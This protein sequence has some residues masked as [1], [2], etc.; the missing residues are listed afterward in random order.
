L[1]IA[2][3]PDRPP[4]FRIQVVDEQTGRG[5]PLVEL[6]T[7]N[8][9]RYVTDSNGVV[10]FDEPG[11]FDRKVFFSVSSHGYEAAKDG[12]GFPGQAIQIT[13]GGSARIS[14]RRRNIA[15]RLYRVTGA[16]I[17]RDSVLTGDRVS[18][19]EPLLNGRV[20]GQDSVVNA[21]YRGKV[22]WFWG[23]TNRPDYP[24]GN[25]HAPGATSALPGHGGLDPEAGVDLS[26]FLDNSGFARPTA[27]IPGDG[28]TW[29]SGLV[30]LRD[31]DGNE[32]MFANYAKI[33]KMLE[34]YQQGLAEF[35]PDSGRFEKVSQFPDLASHPVDFPTGHTFVHT[36]H[37]VNYVYY[38]NPY[39]LIRVP[40][41]PDQLGNPTAIEAYT[42]LKP[43][44]TRAQA[45]LDRGADGSLRYSWKKKTQVL[46]Q[47]TQNK[48]IASGRI[49]P[50]EALLNLRDVET[51]KTVLGHG[52][53]V[54]WNSFR[55]RW[56][57]IAVESFGGPSFLGEVW[58][59]EGDTPLGPWV[60]ARKV[61][62]HNKYSFYNPKQHPMFDKDGG[63]II[64]FEGTYTT[65]FSGNDHPTPRYDYN[66]VMYRLDLADRR[67]ALPVA[68]YELPAGDGS[69]RF[70][71][72][73]GLKESGEG[74]PRQVAF[75]AP[76]RPGIAGVPVYEE[77]DPNDGRLLRLG[78]GA[79]TPSDRSTA[80]VFY[81]LPDD[82]R[83][84][85]E[86]TVRLYEHQTQAGGRRS[87]SVDPSGRK[88]RAARPGR[89]LGRVW[90]NP[91]TA[92]R[93]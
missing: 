17:Y 53:S 78:T 69:V 81:V 31:R 65:T 28:P 76:D 19:R 24:L 45:Q 7:V 9:V 71:T 63:R 80:P 82:P 11:L 72:R 1:G 58:Y 15:E 16:G 46:P 91:A 67:L 23:D 51:G 56:V 88:V 8:Q 3:A 74:T 34:V 85:D 27:P 90:P 66:Q 13:D 70:T 48:Q 41:D 73:S 61:V 32:R 26:Y 35:R 64:F 5:V 83:G 29:L 49:K 50:R 42:C 57:M 52:G 55:G 62:T 54:Y 12:F 33:R 6:K 22:Y 59:A 68:V 60:Y 87:Y 20:F 43:G 25:F 75:F 39:P 47:D 10:A 4:V 21:V 36:D 79:A 30:V 18:I 86:S 84:L 93:W 89:I 2:G 44:T 92:L 40:A 14:I 37:G 77:P 38:C